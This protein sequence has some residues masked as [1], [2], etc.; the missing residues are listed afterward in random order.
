MKSLFT[1]VC[2][3][4]I[5][6]SSSAQ[7]EL[8]ENVKY[9]G[10]TTLLIPTLGI[11]FT[12][13][14]GW[15]GG[16]ASGSPYMVLADDA[17]EVNIIITADEMVE[18][19]VAPELQ[20]TIALDETISISPKGIIQKED[21]RWWGDYTING[22]AR[23][24][25]CYL[26]VRLG[27]FTIGA[28]CIVMALPSS[29]DRGKKAAAAILK[30]MIFTAPVQSQAAASS[31]INI[32]WNDYLKGKSVKYYYT[33]GDFSDTDF[34]H[35]CSDGSFT[36]SKNTVSGGVTGT[37]TLYDK[38]LGTWQAIGQGDVGSLILTFRDGAKA[39]FQIHYGEG[40]RGRGLYLN[41]YRYFV[42]ASTQCN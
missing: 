7:T 32:P 17:N 11:T 40:K 42:E 41:G 23:E 33:Q 27:E 21:K 31:G 5:S 24:M 13:P 16:I 9:E 6:W 28:G 20:Q 3:V 37:G 30:S 25:Q 4:I 26:E 12:I 34:I 2:G 8:K 38:N 29:F 18:E 1:L 10:L 15:Y 14:E 39:E 35:L 22:V 19:L 36:R